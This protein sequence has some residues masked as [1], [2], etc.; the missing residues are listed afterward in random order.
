VVVRGLSKNCINVEI[1]GVN[2]QWM[3]KGTKAYQKYR[4]WTLLRDLH[5]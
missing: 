2:A 3:F 1:E 4:T 5:Q